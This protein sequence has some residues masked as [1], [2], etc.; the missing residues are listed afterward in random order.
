MSSWISVIANLVVSIVTL[1][2]SNYLGRKFALIEDRHKNQRKAY[3]ECY[4]PLLKLL[5][6]IPR[7]QISYYGIVVHPELTNMRSI[8]TDHF[9]E[10][11]FSHLHYLPKGV[12][13]KLSDYRRASLNALISYSSTGVL[14]QNESL[15][16]LASDLFD[17]ILI[18]M[19]EEAEEL[20]VKLGYPDLAQPILEYVEKH[21]YSRKNPRYLL[22]KERI[23]L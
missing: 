6:K 11:L 7:D 20:S 22:R 18:D 5:L 12:A 13:L 23:D 1:F 17:E 21:A 4:I 16:H 2:I 9:F 19:L 10:F 3:L 14:E 8:R 15:A